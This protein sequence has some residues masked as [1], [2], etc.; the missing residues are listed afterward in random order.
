MLDKGKI[1]HGS[2][3]VIKANGYEEQE[4]KLIRKQ[5]AAYSV[6][7]ILIGGVPLAIDYSTGNIFRP[8]PRTFEYELKKLNQPKP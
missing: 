5:N 3:L 1:Q 8:K 6:A 7:D 2:I 4:Y